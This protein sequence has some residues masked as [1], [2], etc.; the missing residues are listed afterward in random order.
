MTTRRHALALVLA[1][2][3]GAASQATA[4][5]AEEFYKGRQMRLI[6]GHSV[7]N[8][9]DVGARLLAKYLQKHIPGNPSII[10][11]NMTAA[12]SIVAANYVYAQAPRDGTVI[13][14]FSRN[15][16]N[17]A[18]MGQ[19]NIEADPR[20]LQ[21][22]GATSIP[23]RICTAWHT[24]PVKSIADLFQQELIVGS[25]GPSTSNSI[26][27]TVINHVLGTKFR[28]IEGYRGSQDAIL[29]TERGEVQGVCA[30]TGQ[31]RP[32][33]RLINEGK[34]KVLLRSEETP[35]PDFPE[36]PSIFDHVNSD[37]QRQ[38]MRFVFGS[39]EFGRP[40]VFAPEVPKDRVALVR[41]AMAAAA[42]DPELKAEAVKLRLDMSFTPPERLDR[43]IGD[44]YAT[45]P[46]VIEAVKKLVPN[47]Q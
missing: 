1:L 34:L 38:F 23:G 36:A 44:L 39:V 29:A 41:K 22:L 8:D 13:G 4:Q 26:L 15:L 16:P 14:T 7:G 43:L 18:R 5:P 42:A 10:A 35:L 47:M 19:S 31:F 37:A 45:T 40:Y 28:I 11:Q 21:W 33:E 30:T 2:A 46:E 9:Y 17:Q 27:P 3:C 20:R 25:T 6:V 12:Q 24:A 32:A